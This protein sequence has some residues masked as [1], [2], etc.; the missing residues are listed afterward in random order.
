MVENDCILGCDAKVAVWGRF[1]SPMADD[2]IPGDRKGVGCL[3]Q[4]EVIAALEQEVP[5]CGC[6]E[7]LSRHAAVGGWFGRGGFAC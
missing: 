5:R 4:D 7:N 3:D 1:Y 2:C 6:H